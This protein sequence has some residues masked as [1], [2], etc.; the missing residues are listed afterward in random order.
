MKIYHGFLKKCI[1]AAVAAAACLTLLPGGASVPVHAETGT[2]VPSAKDTAVLRV[3]GIEDTDGVVVNAYQIAKQTYSSY[4]VSDLVETEGAGIKD[5]DNPTPEEVKALAS[6]IRNG[7]DGYKTVTSTKLAL[8]KDPKVA[9]KDGFADYIHEGTHAGM[10]LILADG[11]KYMYNPMIVTVGYGNTQ[12]A[13]TLGK[14]GDG[15]QQTSGVD[16]ATSYDNGAWVKRQ[17]KPEFDKSIVNKTPN[18]EVLTK[19]EDLEVNP[20]KK[21]GN[22]PSVTF[23]ISAIVPKYSTQYAAPVFTITDKAD[24]GFDAPTELTVTGSENATDDQLAKPSAKTADEKTLTKDKD[25]TESFKDN[26]FTV[27]LTTNC[28]QN[29]RVQILHI[30]YTVK[31]NGHTTYNEK[32]NINEAKLKYSHSVDSETGGELTSRTRVYSFGINIGD[33]KELTK[34]EKIKDGEKI[35]AGKVLE[36]A[37][38]ALFKAE[39][40]WKAAG[41]SVATATSDKDGRIHFSGL[42]AGNYV[43]KETKAPAEYLMSSTEYRISITPTYADGKLTDYTLTIDGKKGEDDNLKNAYVL[44]YAADGTVTKETAKNP[45][46]VKDMKIN[47]LISTGGRGIGF[48][49]ALAAGLMMAAVFVL[50][51]EKN[52]DRTK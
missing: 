20:S 22:Y 9:G 13:G 7:E 21:D 40:G 27:S 18:G 15:T 25:Y 10:Y 19:V 29:N 4:G 2:T 11:V 52:E 37:E 28:L 46:T 8:T 12:D 47:Q 45:F 35:T 39:E 36:G 30:E 32:A 23:R 49:S 5:L 14:S 24:P 50:R 34:N 51:K 33:D 6:G 42:E 31:M 1:S 43:L 3:K 38:F 16:A 44:K 17:K 26:G 41:A 48:I